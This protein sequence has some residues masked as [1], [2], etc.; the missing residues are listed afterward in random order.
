LR[1]AVPEHTIIEAKPDNPSDDLRLLDPFPELVQYAN[2]FNFE[3]MNSTE[4]SHTPFVIILLQYL[5]KFKSEHQKYPETR[6]EKEAFR[7]AVI[8]GSRNSQ[9]ENFLLKHIVQQTNI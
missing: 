4:H 3:T 2:S 8:R 7:S 5:Q 1:I 9:E 6:Q